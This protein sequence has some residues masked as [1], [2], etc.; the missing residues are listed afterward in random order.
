MYPDAPYIARNGEVNAWDNEAFRE[1]VRATNRTQFIISGIV[2]DVCTSF[3][4]Q[5]LRAEGYSVW[6]NIEASGTVSQLLR[7]SA[8][9]IMINA[10]VHLYGLFAIVSELMRHWGH[11]PGSAEVKPYLDRY[12]PAAGLLFRSHGAA[13]TNGTLLPGQEGL[14]IID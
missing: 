3:L 7:E 6:A 1:A 12:F 5:S 4:A 14:I 9:D 11:T 2:T 8:N 13:V 10:G